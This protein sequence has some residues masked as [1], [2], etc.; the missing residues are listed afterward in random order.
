MTMSEVPQGLHLRPSG[1]RDE[2]AHW[3]ERRQ[4]RVVPSG[5]EQKACGALLT[6]R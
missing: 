3:A 1:T 2:D 4:N 6:A 5:L